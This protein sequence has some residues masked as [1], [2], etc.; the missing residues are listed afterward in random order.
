MVR[1]Y[2]NNVWSFDHLD[3]ALSLQLP[4]LKT[5]QGFTTEMIYGLIVRDG[6]ENTRQGMQGETIIYTYKDRYQI[7][8]TR[9]ANS[10]SPSLYRWQDKHG[11]WSEYNDKGRL[12]TQGNR[13]NVK[14]YFTYDVNARL[15]GIDDDNH[16]RVLAYSYNAS[17]LIS[18]VTDENGRAVSYSYDDHKSEA[19]IDTSLI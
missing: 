13:N 14:L 1:R 3:N 15:T 16:N 18:Q 10:L 9:D 12:L 7:L 19:T 11:N 17:G 4:L 8:A 2:K 5:Y 6:L